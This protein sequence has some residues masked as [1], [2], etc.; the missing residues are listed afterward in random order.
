[1]HHPFRWS[2][3]SLPSP[4]PYSLIPRPIGSHLIATPTPY[5]L[6]PHPIGPPISLPS[7]TP[8]SL[9]PH[10]IGLPSHCHPPHPTHWSHIP[11]VPHLIA[12]PHTLLI[13]PSSHWSSISL[14]SPTPYSLAPHLIDPLLI[15][16]P[17]HK[18]PTILFELIVPP[19]QC[20]PFS[21][22]R[23]AILVANPGVP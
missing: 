15:G 9:I 8:Y 4:T 14:P 17:I 16:P 21:L 6:V 2:P 23:P 3:I 18:Y 1:M 19:S 13:G 7:P 12:I 11:L 22:V 10:P 20:S 5:S